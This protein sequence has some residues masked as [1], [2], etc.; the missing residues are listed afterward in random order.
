MK[1]LFLLAAIVF[2]FFD[3]KSLY[4]KYEYYYLHN[5][6][7]QNGIVG[8]KPIARLTPAATSAI[9]KGQALLKVPA[10]EIMTTFDDYPWAKYFSDQTPEM[11][12]SAMLISY[13]LDNS[14]SLSRSLYIHQ[15]SADIEPPGHWLEEDLKKWFEKYTEYSHLVRDKF[16]LYDKFKDIAMTIEDNKSLAYE[17]RTYAWAQAVTRT[18]GID[19]SKK[20]WKIMRGL[21]VDEDL[22]SLVIGYAFVPLFELFNQYL[23]PDRFHPQGKYPVEFGSDGFVLYAQ[24]D[25]STGDE[26]YVPYR[27]KSNH[28]LFEDYGTSIPF[29]RHSFMEITV[30]IYS[31]LCKNT[32]NGCTFRLYP[33]EV[34][35]NYLEYFKKEKD[36]L[37]KYRQGVKDA[38]G[39]FKFALRHQRRRVKI[40][41]DRN[42]KQVFHLSI[43]EKWTAYKVLA[44]VDRA[45][46]KFQLASL[47]LV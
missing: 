38:I 22:D 5:S 43:S 30:P 42:L 45:I 20:D 47:K 32:D 44:L 29:N 21:P 23:V 34:D 12:A 25:F 46:L 4:E 18:F 3:V 28:Q 41:E 2:G 10:S 24:R 40:L 13:K 1:T 16:P 37:R 27:S 33:V 11:I 39:K 6:Y 35:K 26:I 17:V 9:S 31:D 8:L 19:I 14:T 7:M 15:F 36:P